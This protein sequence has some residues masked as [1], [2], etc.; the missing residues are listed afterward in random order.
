MN[1]TADDDGTEL[2]QARRELE[3]VKARRPLVDRLVIWSR[4]AR[5]ENNFGSRLDQ[6]FLEGRS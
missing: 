1:R 3:E 6:L 4:H 2:D 5:N